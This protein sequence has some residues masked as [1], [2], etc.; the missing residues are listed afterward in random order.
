MLPIPN[1]TI[2]PTGHFQIMKSELKVKKN[3]I[4]LQ[5]RL[6]PNVR[7]WIKNMKEFIDNM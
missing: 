6:A 5:D 2:T 4:F 1:P 3:V 7:L